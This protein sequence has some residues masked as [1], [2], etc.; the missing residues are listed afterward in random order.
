VDRATRRHFFN[1]CDPAEALAPDDPRNVD[2]DA[3]GAR[4][5]RWVETLAARIA[6]SERPVCELFT[7]IPGA[8]VTTELLRLA[9]RLRDKNGANLL[10]VHIDAADVLD[11]Y[12]PI[13]GSDILLAVVQRAEEAVAAASGTPLAEPLRRLRKWLVSTDAETANAR[14]VES[15]RANPTARDKVRVQ[16]DADLSRFLA[17]VRDELILLTERAR[18]LGHAG[19][20]VIFDGLEKLRGI[21]TNRK[22]V[23]DSAERVFVAGAP[24]RTLP[25]H[26]VYTLP[27]ALILRLDTPVHFLP[28]IALT[29]RAE[30]RREAGFAAAREILHRRVPEKIQDELFGAAARFDRVERLISSS[31]GS[32]RELVRLL[33]GCIAEP[34]LDEARLTRLLSMATDDFLGLIPERAHA[35][36]ARVHQRKELVIE[37]GSEREMAET[38]LA[39]G[40]ILRYQDDVGWFDLHPAARKLPDIAAAIEHRGA[41]V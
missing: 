11:L 41:A 23:L 34:S 16:V 9:A 33:Q 19:L 5:V 25:I 17:E 29:D 4:G 38:M 3:F 7:G 37:D 32:P 28:W 27:A 26:V 39:N 10:I 1:L 12:R 13:D 36:L 2:I 24:S 30:G 35:W 14:L 18:R 22:E 15:L 40:V 21:S 20:A 6:L 31:C 8:G